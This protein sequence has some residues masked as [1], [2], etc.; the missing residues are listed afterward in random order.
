[1]W[2]TSKSIWPFS[3]RPCKNSRTPAASGDRGWR[4]AARPCG[5]DD[6]DGAAAYFAGVR[7]CCR[8]RSVDADLVH[9]GGTG[10]GADKAVSRAFA[11]KYNAP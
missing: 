6:A 3:G 5:P 4:R 1:M 10:D 2:A 11:S 7:G 8:G 9:D